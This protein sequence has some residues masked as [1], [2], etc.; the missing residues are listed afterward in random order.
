MNLITPIA[1]YNDFIKIVTSWTEKIYAYEYNQGWTL[2]EAN[3]AVDSGS[4][5][6]EI[7]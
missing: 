5:L 1:S 2:G 6:S 3:E 7:P 4:P